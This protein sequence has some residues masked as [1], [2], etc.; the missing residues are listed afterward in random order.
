M[1]N[2]TATIKAMITLM[3]DDPERQGLVDT[4]N[5]VLRSWK[6]LFSGYEED[7]QKIL[8]SFDEPTISN[9]GEM[10]LLKNCE[11]VSFCEHHL[12]PF[13][14]K[15]H[16]AYIT[17]LNPNN[18][19]PRIV[20]VSKLARVLECYA[21]RLQLQE[22][23]CEQVT[24]ALWLYLAPQGAACI[25]EATHL[26]MYCRGVKKQQAQLTTSSL[27]GVF[28]DNPSARQELLALIRG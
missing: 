16:I 7:P 19:F 14:G 12:L 11:F 28:R 9:Y 15:A 17:A 1:L 5:R 2:P 20:G 6:E 21:K 10:V 25:I 26:C 8:T 4:P 3:G 27:Q 23:I 24:K 22:R 13:S 18:G